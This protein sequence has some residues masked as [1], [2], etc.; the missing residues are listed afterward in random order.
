MNGS[1]NCPKCLNGCGGV[2]TDCPQNNPPEKPKR[3]RPGRKP[4]VERKVNPV[5]PED[6]PERDERDERWREDT[7]L[8]IVRQAAIPPRSLYKKEHDRVA[9]S[10]AR[11]GATEIEIA[12]ALGVSLSAVRNWLGTYSTFEQAVRLGKEAA[13]ARV[14][15]SLYAK[16]IGYEHDTVKIFLAKNGDP[17]TVPYREHLPPDTVA[18]ITWLKLR[19]PN[20]WRD[21]NPEDGDRDITIRVIGG[22]PPEENE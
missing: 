17:V 4:K 3:G 14:E 12:D 18:C 21:K 10:M 2:R 1:A 15:R 16:A 7:R 20:E 13:D 22:L 5:A 8:G 19:K 11:L 9:A 6:M